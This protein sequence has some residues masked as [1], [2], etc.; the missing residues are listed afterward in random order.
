MIK[1][2]TK[3]SNKKYKVVTKSGTVV[4]LTNAQKLYA[5]TKLANPTMSLNKVAKVAYPNQKRDTLSQQA[6]ANEK[7]KDISIY[8]EEQANRAM[9]TVV[10]LLDS[11]KDDM[12]YRAATDILDRTYGK[13]VQ[14]QI[15]QNTNVNVN[16]EAS[17]ELADNFTEFM[18]QSTT[19]TEAL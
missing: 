7:N 9:V 10:E 19:H 16:I 12:R 8:S 1:G 18:R 14:K 15:T 6:Q 11:K 2:S 13:S 17:K 3:G 4:M 5:D